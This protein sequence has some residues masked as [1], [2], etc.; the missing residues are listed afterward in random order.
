[1]EIMVP[2][3]SLL[4]AA[5]LGYLLARY[6]AKA[7]LILWALMG[8]VLIGLLVS[9]N[10]ATGHYA[11]MGEFILIMLVWLPAFLGLGIVTIL[12]RVLRG[13]ALRRGMAS[14]PPLR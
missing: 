13:R 14:A 3:I 8:I 5:L 6:T 1:M 2:V 11:G 10:T 7:V 4:A 12:G 9:A